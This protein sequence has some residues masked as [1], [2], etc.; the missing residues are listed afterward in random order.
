M[1]TRDILHVIIVTF[2]DAVVEKNFS[3]IFFSRSVDWFLF[4]V[5]SG[6]RY[7]PTGSNENA[8]VMH[9]LADG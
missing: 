9:L 8:L 3:L 6:N 1:V 2:L 5:M 7:L 4:K